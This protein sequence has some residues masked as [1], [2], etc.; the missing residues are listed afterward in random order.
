MKL[1]MQVGRN[2]PGDRILALERG[3]EPEESQETRFVEI[4]EEVKG[5]KLL[6]S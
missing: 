2:L 4:F 1:W 3:A 6:R 5:R